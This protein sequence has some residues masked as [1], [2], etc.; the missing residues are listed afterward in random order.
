MAE[1]KICLAGEITQVSIPRQRAI[2]NH[3]ISNEHLKIAVSFVLKKRKGIVWIFNINK[4]ADEKRGNAR[5][6]F[7]SR[8]RDG[9]LWREVIYTKRLDALGRGEVYSCIIEMVGRGE[10]KKKKKIG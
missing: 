10:K 8:A 9:G 3:R 1:N 4:T 7:F 2:K 5:S 6:I